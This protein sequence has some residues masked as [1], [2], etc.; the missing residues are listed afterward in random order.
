[1]GTVNP[2]LNFNGNTEEAFNFYKSVFGGEFLAVMR[3]K[4]NAECGQV[5]EADKE[6][7][8]HIALPIGNGN[9]LMATD[10]L[11]SMGQKLTFGNN[12][13]IALAPESKEEAERLFN[14]L[15]A[16][17]KIEMPLQDMFWGAY[18][19]SFADKFGVQ[20]MVNYSKNQHQ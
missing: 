5:S 17:G 14:G 9:V 15:S 16:G 20:W 18:Y 6:R 13:Y 10:A 19:G 8:M 2:Y 3:F 11:E 7:I 12:F 1:M 4:D